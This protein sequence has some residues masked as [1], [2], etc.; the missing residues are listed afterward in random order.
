MNAKTK[1]SHGLNESMLDASISE[2]FRRAGVGFHYEEGGCWGFAAAMAQHLKEAGAEPTV[3]VRDEGFV[4]AM[5]VL[6]GVRYD[7]RGASFG[8][9]HGYR[10][11]HPH[12][13]EEIAVRNGVAKSE[14][15][16]D[17]DEAAEIL[18]EALQSMD[19]PAPRREARE[20]A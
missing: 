1:P 18:R 14:F 9:G 8:N 12:E 6:D 20:C 17:R 4:H 2:A 11:V 5:V 13:L 16:A 15:Q 10:P 7:Y 19:R 3:V